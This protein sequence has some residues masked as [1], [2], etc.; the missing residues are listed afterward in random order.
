MIKSGFL[1][2]YKE[3]GN[4]SMTNRKSVCKLLAADFAR[5]FGIQQKEFPPEI[6]RIIQTRDFRYSKI[7]GSKRGEVIAGIAKRIQDGD[8]WISGPDKKD[9]WERGWGEN[10]EEYGKTGDLAN[11][12][13]AYIRPNQILRLDHEY[14]QPLVPDFEYNV[15]DVWRRWVFLEYLKGVDAIYEFGCG[16][17]QHLPALVELFP[18]KKIF[19]LD[20]AQSSINI[21]NQLKNNTSWKIEGRLFNLYEPNKDFSL[22]KNPGVL[23]IGTMEQLGRNFEPFL[24]FLLSRKPSIVAHME[25]IEEL[26]DDSLPTD[27]LALEFIKKRNY[28]QGYLTRLRAL[29]KEGV[30]EIVRVQRVLY[31]GPHHD[32]F[33][34][35]AWRPK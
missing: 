17:C 8:F 1:F 5:L 20:W 19:G 30:I 15:V 2:T 24:Q 18:E 16:S 31:G 34:L 3:L 25:T 14:I 29:E 9:R 13:P 26:Y 33:S 4:A 28:L 11:L 12:I 6:L 32:S 7:R 21:I 22:E 27:H 10:L 23:T 35:I